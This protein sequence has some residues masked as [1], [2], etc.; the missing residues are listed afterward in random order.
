MKWHSA[1]DFTDEMDDLSELMSESPAGDNHGRKA[2]GRMPRTYNDRD[3]QAWPYAYRSL[4][5]SKY[6]NF[7]YAASEGAT[8]VHRTDLNWHGARGYEPGERQRLLSPAER[9]GLDLTVV[10]AAVLE[11]LGFTEADLARLDKPGRPGP[12]TR[13]LRAR[14]DGRLLEVVEANGGTGRPGKSGSGTTHLARSLGWDQNEST[15]HSPRLNKSLRRARKARAGDHSDLSSAHTARL[16]A[17]QRAEPAKA[18]A[19][20]CLAQ[21]IRK[22]LSC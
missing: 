7:Q 12:E 4:D 15:G 14:F 2:S 19:A 22:D 17:A 3:G 13:A 1:E 16:N 11:E 5:S 8:T 18:S 20:C 6:A 9:A 10:R 21:R